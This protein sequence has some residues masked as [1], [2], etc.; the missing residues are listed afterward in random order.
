MAIEAPGYKI[1]HSGGLYGIHSPSG[2]Y[3]EVDEAITVCTCPGYRGRKRCKH[4]EGMRKLRVL[5]PNF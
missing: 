2:D 3:Y 1:V 5:C 4:L